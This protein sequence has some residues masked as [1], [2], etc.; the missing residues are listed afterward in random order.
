MKHA[1]TVRT[2]FKNFYLGETPE[3]LPKRES[4]DR[5]LKR[6][7]KWSEGNES[8]VSQLTELVELSRAANY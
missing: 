5:G 4:T 8:M 1:N 7:E 6:K 3:L 2:D